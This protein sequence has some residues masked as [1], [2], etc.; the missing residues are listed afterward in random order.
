[1]R[2]TSALKSELFD[3]PSH[4]ELELESDGDCYLLLKQRHV[5]HFDEHQG[6]SGGGASHSGLVF[7]TL[8]IA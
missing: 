8:D 1:M 6:T 7:G 2:R 5:G 4:L 3:D